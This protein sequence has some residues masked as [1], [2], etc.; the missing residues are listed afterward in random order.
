MDCSRTSGDSFSLTIRRKFMTGS[1]VTVMGK[2]GGVRIST[3]KKGG[4]KV[5]DNSESVQHQVVAHEPHHEEE[6]NSPPHRSARRAMS[7]S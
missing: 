5:I 7:R 6:T 2:L 4:C 1:V 3:V